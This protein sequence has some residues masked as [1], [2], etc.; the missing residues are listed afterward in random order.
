MIR[1]IRMLFGLFGTKRLYFSPATVSEL[2]WNAD[3]AK[4]EATRHEYVG[5]IERGLSN[6]GNELWYTVWEIRRKADNVFVGAFRMMGPPDEEYG[7]S[8]DFNIRDEFSR[9]GYGSEAFGKVISFLMSE[10]DCSYVKCKADRT[11]AASAKFLRKFGFK[12]TGADSE[13][14]IYEL[15]KAKRVTVLPMTLFGAALTVA[16]R[17]LVGEMRPILWAIVPVCFL[18]GAVLEITDGIRRKKRDPISKE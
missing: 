4:D 8:L 3:N 2:Q 12:K 15:E 14:T 17:L 1:Q 9:R 13:R 6:P 7:V 11:D 16:L 5:I 10:K 18:I